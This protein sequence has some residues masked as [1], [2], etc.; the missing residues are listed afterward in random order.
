MHALVHKAVQQ[1]PETYDKELLELTLEF[2][3][4]K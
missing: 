2:V 3:V 4:N 1:K